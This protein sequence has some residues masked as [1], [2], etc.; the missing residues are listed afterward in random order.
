MQ[1]YV[2]L[3]VVNKQIYTLAVAKN[4]TSAIV[5]KDHIEKQMSRYVP[6]TSV[7]MQ[8]C[9]CFGKHHCFYRY[10]G[11]LKFRRV[12]MR[13]ANFAIDIMAFFNDG[14]YMKKRITNY[15]KK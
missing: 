10:H 15:Y 4:E 3:L 8:K 11:K 7:I 14:G 9:T 13:G 2:I 1:K 5:A 6:N 12:D